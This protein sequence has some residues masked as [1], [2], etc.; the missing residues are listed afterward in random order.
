VSAQK[1]CDKEVRGQVRALRED[2]ERTARH[3]AST[4][5]LESAKQAEEM[6]KMQTQ[7][8]AYSSAQHTYT[9]TD[10]RLVC[11]CLQDASPPCL[12]LMELCLRVTRL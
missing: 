6:L 7:F 9:S 3:H 4:Q 11:M 12:C 2:A 10:T 1:C 8:N 5:K